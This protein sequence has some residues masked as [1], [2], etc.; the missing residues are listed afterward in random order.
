MKPDTVEIM[1]YEERIPIFH[2]ASSNPVTPKKEVPLFL[3]ER[4]L[5]QR[6]QFTD[7]LRRLERYFKPLRDKPMRIEKNHTV[8]KAGVRYH[9]EDDG[10]LTSIQ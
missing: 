5:K 2:L 4:Y 6:E 3:Y 1:K 8:L 9:V 7:T 10:S